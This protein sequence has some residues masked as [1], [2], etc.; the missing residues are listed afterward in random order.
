MTEMVFDRRNRVNRLKPVMPVGG[1]QT[2]EISAPL[3]THWRAATCAEVDCPHYLNGWSTTVLTGS[4]DEALIKSSGRKT[5]RVERQAD[6]FMRYVFG[7]G[8]PCFAV[9][10]HKVLLGRPELFILREG[11]WRWSGAPRV[12]ERPDQW[13]DHFADHQDK[14]SE[15]VN[16]G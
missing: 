5:I 16:R 13:V 9:T 14:I 10:R 15:K 1:M 2:Y 3:S 4:A 7:S 12:F 8:Q 6:G 11:D